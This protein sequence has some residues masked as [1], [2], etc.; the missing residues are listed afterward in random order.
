MSTIREIYALKPQDAGEVG[1]E[2]EMEGKN[3]HHGPIAG[4]N[5]HE[6][7]SLRG[8]SIEFVLKKPQTR[9]NVNKKLEALSEYLKNPL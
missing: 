9:K 4:W 8:D 2:I 3:I 5:M 6:D 7:G 1:I